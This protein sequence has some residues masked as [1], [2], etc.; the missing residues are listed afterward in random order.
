MTYSMQ[1]PLLLTTL[2]T[3]QLPADDTTGAPAPV[4]PPLDDYLQPAW[5]QL[6]DRAAQFRSAAV[7]PAATRAFEQQLQLQVREIARLTAQHTY[8]ALEPAAVQD[9]PKHVNCKGSYTRLNKKTP[10]NV[11]ALFGQ[12][13]LYRVGYRSTSKDGSPT[14][15]PLA[16]TLGLIE[17]A[18]PALAAQ[19]GHLF[20]STGMTQGQARQRLRQDH[21]VGWGVA[22]LRAVT[23]RV[24]EMLAPQRQA[25]QV[26]R[27][28]KLLE[29]AKA[30]K[31]PHE[32]VLSVGRDGISLGIRIKKGNVFEMATTG[33][34]SVLD[35]AGKR[36]GTVYLAYVPEAE[37][38][39]MSQQLTRLVRA[40]LERWPGALPRLCYVTDAG[41]C[42][43]SYYKQV[44]TKMRHPRT[45]ERLKWVRV[46]DYYHA[47]QRLWTMAECLFGKGQQATSWA[48]KMQKWL[49]KPSGANRVLH[50][51][52]WYRSGA[53]L[54]GKKAEDFAKAYRYL[55][56]RMKYLR[57][58]EYKQQ[59][60]PLGSGVTEAACKT[61]FTQ[62]LK[63][64]GMRWD[65]PGAQVVL[66]LRV[67]LLSDVWDAAFSK[68]LEILPVVTVPV[69]KPLPSRSTDAAA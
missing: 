7:S 59:G 50:S 67:L 6:L 16:H 45:K 5:Q 24:A 3:T 39:R 20:A 41:T 69:R 27:L 42:E 51:A 12:V 31:G 56:K 54:E 29:Q 30:S 22:K 65:K 26:D 35:R 36:L 19:V 47:S 58:H 48:R 60:L 15:F 55:R 23:A 13:R 1:L 9:L 4:Q 62:R 46:L 61:V 2:L 21:G 33:T 18:T 28:L 8:N 44:L 49:K 40:V 66:D 57:Y 38:V 43:T 17:G 68:A 64:S 10:Q 32:P 25:C 52:A 53:N 63:L 37:Q 11:W 34:V 14:L